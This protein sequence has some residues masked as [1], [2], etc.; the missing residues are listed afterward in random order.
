MPIHEYRCTACGHE[1]EELVRSKNQKLVCPKC[2][3]TSLERKLSTFAAVATGG[4]AEACPR[5][6]GC[7]QGDCCGQGMCNLTG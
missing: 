3:A 4:G 5:P 2:A 6:G 1:F 7:E